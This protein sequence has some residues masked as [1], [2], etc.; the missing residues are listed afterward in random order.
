M[1]SKRVL[2]ECP[3]AHNKLKETEVNINELKPSA[4]DRALAAG[5]SQRGAKAALANIDSNNERISEAITIAMETMTEVDNN[6]KK[7]KAAMLW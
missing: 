3:G 2:K 1:A 4:F 5:Y 6:Y 7:I